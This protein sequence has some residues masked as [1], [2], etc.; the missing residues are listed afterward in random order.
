MKAA[1][2]GRAT[3]DLSQVC[4]VIPM[5]EFKDCTS[6]FGQSFCQLFVSPQTR[7]NA[8]SLLPRVIAMH[9]TACESD[10]NP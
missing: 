5:P 6:G 10:F 4:N 3:I 7:T 1:A 2:D 8:G 9:R